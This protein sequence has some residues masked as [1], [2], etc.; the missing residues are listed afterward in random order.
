MSVLTTLDGYM[1][2]SAYQ[3]KKPGM[4]GQEM[5]SVL[6]REELEN[7]RVRHSWR[8]LSEVFLLGYSRYTVG[9]LRDGHKSQRVLSKTQGQ[10][11]LGNGFL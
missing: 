4:G 11:S 10:G 6:Q 7:S 9:L 2:V 5:Y 3:D 8:P 1:F